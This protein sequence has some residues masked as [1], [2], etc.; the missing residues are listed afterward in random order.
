MLCF[1]PYHV[2]TFFIRKT[3]SL[4]YDLV[5]SETV[6]ERVCGKENVLNHLSIPAACFTHPE[7][8]MVGLTEVPSI[9]KLLGLF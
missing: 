1:L 6:V 7:I 8:S 9:I 4:V 3:V 5:L 2:N